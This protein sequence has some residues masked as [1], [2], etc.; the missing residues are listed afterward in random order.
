MTTTA[1]MNET[2]PRFPAGRCLHELF[3]DQAR[4][5]PED[6][7]VVSGTSS[8]TYADLDGRATRLAAVLARHGAGPDVPVGVWLERSTATVVALL[9][10]LKA[11]GAYVPLDPDVPVSRAKQIMDEAAAPVVVAAAGRHADLDVLDATVVAVDEAGAAVGLPVPETPETPPTAR[12]HPENLISIYY[13]SGSTGAPK[14]VASTH[15]G[16]VN[17]MCWMQ[18]YYDLRPGEGV[19]HKT[20]LSFDDSAVE[21]FWPLIVGGVVVLL[22]PDQHR[23]PRSILDAAIEHGVAVLHFVPT[24]LAGFLDELTDED[25][26]GLRNL[27]HV[28]S[29]GETLRLD[30]VRAFLDRLAPGGCRLVNQWGATEVSIDSVAHVCTR[31][32]VATDDD[33]PVGKPMTGTRVHVLDGDMRPVPDGTVGELYIAGI[34]LARGYWR[35]PAATAAAFGPDPFGNGDRLYR[36]GDLGYRRPDG[37]VMFLGRADH[38][39]KIRGIRVEPAEIEILLRTHPDVEEAVVVKWEVTPDDTRL[40]AYLT[41]ARPGEAPDVAGIRAFLGEQL[42][43]Y[44]VPAAFAVLDAIPLTASG[45][46]DRRRLPDPVPAAGPAEDD[47]PPVTEAEL[48]V[49]QVWQEILGLDKVGA[50]QD[51]FAL[52]GHSILA[53]RVVTRLRRD[54]GVDLPLT[55]VFEHPTVA[56]QAEIL[57]RT[58][59]DQP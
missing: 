58:L 39:V 19:L 38:Q 7:A 6:V 53:T 59:D 3:E 24:V 23:D 35:A 52:G 28:V 56:S 32:D 11:G 12:V 47:S 37:G 29:S 27:R 2:G 42:P 43:A 10:V 33:V 55:L 15:R 1:A 9:A 13:T 5:T 31:D 17:R 41:P 22:P 14:G 44:M 18:E 54:L 21:L 25:V 16:W 8:V 49:A 50:H 51:F 34:G 30:L 57:L 45:K 36:T 26:K 40:A 46:I 48:L 20:V 4:L